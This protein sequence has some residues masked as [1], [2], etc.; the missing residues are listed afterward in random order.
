MFSTSTA[1]SREDWI[2]HDTAIAPTPIPTIIAG[3]GSCN[4]I[5]LSAELYY[6]Y[7]FCLALI[8]TRYIQIV[9][10]CMAPAQDDTHIA[11]KCNI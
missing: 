1:Q 7:F 8:A 9:K 10:F 4:N 5:E 2:Q 11:Q 6:L 3:N